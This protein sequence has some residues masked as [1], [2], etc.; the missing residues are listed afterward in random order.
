M[1]IILPIFCLLLLPLLGVNT[2]DLQVAMQP[3]TGDAK[4]VYTAPNF[5]PEELKG[6]LKAILNA[7]Y[8]EP[9][10]MIE[11]DHSGH[12]TLLNLPDNARLKESI[13]TYVKNYPQV[14]SVSV[15]DSKKYRP[16]S[17]KTFV[18]FP[19][20]LLFYPLLANPFELEMGW[21][22]FVHNTRPQLNSEN[23]LIT[24]FSIGGYFPLARWLSANNSKV[25]T[26]FDFAA[27]NQSILKLIRTTVLR[28]M[29]YRFALPFSIS[30][31]VLSYRFTLWHFCSHLGDKFAVKLYKAG[32]YP[33]SK[34]IDIWPLE[35]VISAQSTSNYRLYF[36]GGV[37]TY[38]QKATYFIYG[39]ECYFLQFKP[40]H[41][42]TF[43][44][45][46]LAFDG[47]NWERFN[48]DPSLS[49]KLGI[50]W[51]H[52][53]MADKQGKFTIIYHNGLGFG[54]YL[55]D[56]Q[57]YVTAGFEYGF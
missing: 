2:R 47:Q 22:A 41:S 12:V 25:A 30:T 19:Q 6:A 51:G 45:P 11:V 49:I 46:F 50:S 37:G 54:P 10:I 53:P 32:E 26:Q 14:A 48:Y 9:N 29:S 56:R 42:K 27:K 8:S 1:R 39:A 33:R 5:D 35:L 44:Q 17:P 16:I 7:E 31:E 20:T 15:V 24:D 55:F 3:K 13:I 52:L 18:S 21:S 28:E 38:C 4:S 23:V 57:E 34:A 36:G 40:N 43:Y